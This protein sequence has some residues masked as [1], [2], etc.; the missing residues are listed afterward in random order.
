VLTIKALWLVNAENLAAFR[1][2]PSFFFGLYK[3][4]Y[5]EISD[6]FK[7]GDHAH[8]VLGSIA[9]IQMLEPVARKAV[10]DKAVFGFVVHQLFAF[11]DFAFCAGFR[12]RAIVD[13]ASWAWF[14]LSSEC[15]AETAIHATRSDQL[16][17]D[18]D[19]FCRSL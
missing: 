13:P 18:C 5:A 8:A 3:I 17:G 12:F 19:R 1:A 14:P 6:A 2:D 9:L 7:I 10:T 15:Q 11:L 16:R 4:P